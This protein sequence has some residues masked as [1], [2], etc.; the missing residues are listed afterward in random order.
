MA[1]FGEKLIKNSAFYHE[2]HS[3]WRSPCGYPE[4]TQLSRK[5]DVSTLD[6][7]QKDM[8]R[9]MRFKGQGYGTIAKQLGMDADRVQDY[10]RNHGLAGDGNLVRLN[11]PVW[12]EQNGRCLICCRKVKQPRV[13]RRKRFC[14]GRCR[15]QY[16]RERKGD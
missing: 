2:K 6:D 5:K 8:I 11:Y 14:S 15:T 3:T 10:C 12:C 4:V 13:G 16:C 9:R 1:I 7:T